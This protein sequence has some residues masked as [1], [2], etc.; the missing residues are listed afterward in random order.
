MIQKSQ[1]KKYKN[2]TEIEQEWAC[3]H[4]YAFHSGIYAMFHTHCEYIL[5]LFCLHKWDHHRHHYPTKEKASSRTTVSWIILLH[6]SQYH[7]PSVASIVTLFTMNKPL[8]LPWG[9]RQCLQ[10]IP[11]MQRLPDTVTSAIYMHSPLPADQNTRLW[12]PHTDQIWK[13]P[14]IQ[15]KREIRLNNTYNWVPGPPHILHLSPKA[16]CN[17]VRFW[18]E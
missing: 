11:Q 4:R 15:N 13:D 12:T 18:L 6:T 5:L 17:N 10:R 1:I 14:E 8:L 2:S 16:A 7:I 3:M 9:S